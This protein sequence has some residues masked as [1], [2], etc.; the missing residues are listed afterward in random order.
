M[1]TANSFGQRKPEHKKLE[2]NPVFTVEQAFSSRFAIDSD[3]KRGLTN[4]KGL[5]QGCRA[6]YDSFPRRTGPWKVPIFVHI[7]KNGGTSVRV[8]LNQ[9]Q[10]GSAVREGRLRWPLLAYAGH[11]FTIQARVDAVS[12]DIRRKLTLWSRDGRELHNHRILEARATAERRRK[13]ERGKVKRRRVGV[14]AT[15]GRE[16]SSVH[17]REPYLVVLRDPVT[18]F[19]SAFYYARRNYANLAFDRTQQHVAKWGERPPLSAFRSPY[20]LLD[21]LSNKSHLLH[22]RAHGA[23]KNKRKNHVLDS[24]YK[25]HI[26]G[27]QIAQSWIWAP[28]SEW[29]WGMGFSF[30]C[31]RESTV[32]STKPMLMRKKR[33]PTALAR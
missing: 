33:T 20:D 6:F 16:E 18:R 26:A 11:S 29:L 7:A 12:Q 8:W 28:Q 13:R 21:A 27:R 1:E 19:L 22:E 3:T 32:F 14:E 10:A 4:A 15:S 9:T 5:P 2:H 23:L 31:I 17:W 24:G 30:Y 25:H